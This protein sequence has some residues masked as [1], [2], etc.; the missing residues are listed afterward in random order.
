MKESLLQEE[1]LSIKQGLSLRVTERKGVWAEGTASA[2]A[3]RYGGQVCW[4]DSGGGGWAVKG[5][6]APE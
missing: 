2:K 6:E 1:C 5:V 3:W 4:A